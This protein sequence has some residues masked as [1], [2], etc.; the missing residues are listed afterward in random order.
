M[1][2]FLSGDKTD[3]KESKD[4]NHANNKVFMKYFLNVKKSLRMI[5]LPFL[6]PYN[7]PGEYGAKKATL[8]T[9][10]NIKLAIP[11]CSRSINHRNLLTN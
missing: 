3:R 11:L 7:I 4:T 6:F 9:K 1:F 5:I 2:Q 8:W 10:I